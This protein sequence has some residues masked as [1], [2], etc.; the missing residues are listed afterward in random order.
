MKNRALFISL[1]LLC[2]S[3][4]LAG[5]PSGCRH[6]GDTKT[7]SLTGDVSMEMVWCPAGTFM[8]GSPET[9]LDRDTNET[10]HEIT[11]SN[12]F[13]LGKYEVTKE[14][15][16]AIMGTKPWQ[17]QD[18]VVDD[19]ES[20]ATYLSWD[21]TQSFITAANDATGLSLALPTEAQWEYACRA[22]TTTRFYWGDDP[23]YTD[24]AGYAWYYANTDDASEAYAHNV[25]L[26]SSN[27]WGFYDMIGNISEWCQDWYK[28]DLGDGDETDPDGPNSG[29]DKV[30]RGG[31]WSSNPNNCRAANR[32]HKEP[33]LANVRYG[34]R[35]VQVP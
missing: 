10:Q 30:Q 31:S 28:E 16:Y 19:M 7:I 5:C 17:D 1:C 35:M 18:D 33:G 22:G 6:A 2:G 3:L 13:W 25:G 11:L 8:S 27:P 14:Q 24:I 15:W 12:G 9:E 34:F 20:P 32:T 29:T 23:L 21:D 4:V 26:K